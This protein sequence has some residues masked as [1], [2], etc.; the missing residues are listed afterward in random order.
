MSTLHIH[1][2]VVGPS[3]APSSVEVLSTT[4]GAD[5]WFLYADIHHGPDAVMT[6][7]SK[8]A[9]DLEAVFLELLVKR[10]TL[11]TFKMS[12]SYFL[13]LFHRERVTVTEKGAAQ[14]ANAYEEALGH[15]LEVAFSDTDFTFTTVQATSK[16]LDIKAY[17]ISNPKLVDA[18]LAS[19]IAAFK[20]ANKVAPAAPPAD[21]PAEAAAAPA[22]EEP[23]E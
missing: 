17:V 9:P 16:A 8:Y 5:T 18:S 11:G 14:K 4:Q 1:P 3:Q 10:P 22:A 7:L 13:Q 12:Q 6:N 21:A 19:K 15:M 20:T 2:S 23:A